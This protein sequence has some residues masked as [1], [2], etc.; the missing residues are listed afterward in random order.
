MQEI[1]Q[2]SDE[3]DNLQRF[4]FFSIPYLAVIGDKKI[5]SR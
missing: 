5:F 3:K 2:E 4:G 1:D